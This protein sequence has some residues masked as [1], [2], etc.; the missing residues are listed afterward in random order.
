MAFLRDLQWIAVVGAEGEEGG[1]IG[2]EQ[3]R[4]RVQVRAQRAFADEDRHSLLKLLQRLFRGR[5]LVLGADAGGQIAIEIA[6]GKHR[7][8][9]VD[10]AAGECREL[11]ERCWL[12]G[13]QAREIHELGEPDDLRVRSQRREIG[14]EQFRA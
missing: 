6:A 12:L 14:R 8:M 13:Q 4:N 2:V 1:C 3:R 5:R 7:R 10:V 9:T 11:V